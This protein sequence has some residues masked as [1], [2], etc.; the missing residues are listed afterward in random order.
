MSGILLCSQIER[1]HRL[2]KDFAEQIEDRRSLCNLKFSIY[3]LLKQRDFHMM[4]G[5]KD[6]ND[7]EKIKNDSI[8]KYLLNNE[9]AS[10]P[11]MSRFENS[12]DKVTA[13]KQRV[14]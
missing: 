13:Q 4:Q 5:Y 3:E 10:Q 2:L 1:E 7:V 14:N 8:I 11:T 12:I 9:L 6:C